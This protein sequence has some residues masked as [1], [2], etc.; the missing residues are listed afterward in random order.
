M[1]KVSHT[2]A[3]LQVQNFL[4]PGVGDQAGG[5]AGV[6]E[7]RPAAGGCEEPHKEDIRIPIP[8]S[9]EI[10]AYFSPYSE[11]HISMCFSL[12]DFIQA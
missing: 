1:K 12:P 6:G 8:E 5:C 9:T 2:A 11:P 4:P 10:C 7:L 3:K